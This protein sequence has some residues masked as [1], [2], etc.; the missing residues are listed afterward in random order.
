MNEEYLSQTELGR[1]YGV[2]SHVIGRW[3][4]ELGLRTH[5]GKP[6]ELAFANDMVKDRPSRGIGTYF[7]TWHREKTTAR[8]DRAGYPRETE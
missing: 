2:S 4:K 6:S 7:W 1:L 5:K 8:F 3:L